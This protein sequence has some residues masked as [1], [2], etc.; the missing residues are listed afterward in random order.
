MT[1]VLPMSAREKEVGV[2]LPRSVRVTDTSRQ[3]SSDRVM[4]IEGTRLYFRPLEVQDEPLLCKW[5]N[6][7]AVRRYNA[8]RG[9]LNLLREREFIDGQGKN[10]QEYVFGVVAKNGDRLIG[11]VAL[12]GVDSVNR[13]AVLGIAIG[14]TAWQNRGYGSEAIKLLLKY[15]FEELNLNRIGLHVFAENWRAIRTYQKA[16][17]V[18]EG[19]ARQAQYRNGHYQDEYHFA[20]LRSEWETS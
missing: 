11:T 13:S 6:D 19:C 20:M 18:Q 3:E 2:V 14:D 8:H 10:P 4:Y 7:P 12:R 16:G 17:F 5:I 1:S 15:G 9:P